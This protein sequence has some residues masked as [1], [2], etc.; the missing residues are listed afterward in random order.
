MFTSD[1]WGASAA[2]ERIYD[3]LVRRVQKAEGFGMTAYRVIRAGVR[4]RK[5]R[6]RARNTAQP[7]GCMFDGMKRPAAPSETSP[8]DSATTGFLAWDFRVIP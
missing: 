8:A 6:C 5:R 4:V 7:A 3:V 1:M 2:V